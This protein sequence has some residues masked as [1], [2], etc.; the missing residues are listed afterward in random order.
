LLPAS[1]FNVVPIGTLADYYTLS[2]TINADFQQ[3]GTGTPRIQFSRNDNS[4]YRFAVY[5]TGN[6]CL[7]VGGFLSCL[8]GSPSASGLTD[9]TFNDTCVASGTNCS[10]RN[11][12][13]PA[14]V[15]VK[16]YRNNVATSSCDGYIL[17]ITR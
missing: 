15:V 4:A 13:W 7:A 9:W 14:S 12:S 16:V 8:T 5:A 1:G 11:V 3:H 2:F 6:Q 17:R 10:T